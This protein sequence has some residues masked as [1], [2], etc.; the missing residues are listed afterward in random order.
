[1]QLIG[2]TALIT[3][4]GADF[5]ITW[6]FVFGL[7]LLFVVADYAVYGWLFAVYTHDPQMTRETHSLW[8]SEWI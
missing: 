2:C 1:M 6:R 8:A 3:Q 4:F 7:L 5:N